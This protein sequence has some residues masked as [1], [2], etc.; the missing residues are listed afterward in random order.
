MEM[1]VI[2][3]VRVMF[4]I[5]QSRQ[6]RFL[7]NFVAATNEPENK[8]HSSPKPTCNS[9]SS[10]LKAANMEVADMTV[11]PFVEFVLPVP[12]KAIVPHPQPK[13]PL[14]TIDS[15]LPLKKV[16]E[17]GRGGQDDWVRRSS[18][19]LFLQAEQCERPCFAKN[20]AVNLN[21]RNE[22]VCTRVFVD[23]A[24]S[25]RDMNKIT[26]SPLCVKVLVCETEQRERA[27]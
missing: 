4:T 24:A 20:L 7:S 8:Q 15:T 21:G 27:Q 3:S 14:V 5:I 23:R 18:R 2:F 11:S 12:A 17:V 6:K 19:Q 10:H 25:W 26:S 22:Q 9:S 1:H 13:R 16:R